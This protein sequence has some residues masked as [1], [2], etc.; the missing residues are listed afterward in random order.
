MSGSEKSISFISF[1]EGLS[2]GSKGLFSGSGGLERPGAGSSGGFKGPGA[3]SFRGSGGPGASGVVDFEES[4]SLISGR[5]NDTFSLVES[6]VTAT[7]LTA[8]SL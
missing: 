8:E 2:I 1:S 6:L 4:I 5:S 3:G 7:L